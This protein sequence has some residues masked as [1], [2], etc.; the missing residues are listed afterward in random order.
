MRSAKLKIFFLFFLL[1]GILLTAPVF[2]AEG[3][4]GAESLK[5]DLADIKTR[6]S[7]LESGQREIIAKEE[8]ILAELDRIR[9]WVHRK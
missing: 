5:N 1:G 7:A 6:L 4:S 8:K 3:E 9:I 2:A